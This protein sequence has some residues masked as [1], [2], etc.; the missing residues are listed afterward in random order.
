LVY[1][2]VFLFVIRKN[3]KILIDLFYNIKFPFYSILKFY[4]NIYKI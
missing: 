3:L 1:L 2:Q 4:L